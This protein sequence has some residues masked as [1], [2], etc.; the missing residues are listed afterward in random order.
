MAPA[1]YASELVDFSPGESAGFG[2]DSLPD[3]VLGA[4][5]PGHGGAGSLHVLSLGVG[6]SIVLGFG[7][8]TVLD[9][10]GPDLIIFENAFFVGGDPR[11]VFAE[12]AQVAVSTD[13]VHWHPFE[14]EAGDESQGPW[15]GCAGWNPTEDYDVEHMDPLEPERTG[16]DAFDLADLGVKEARYVRITD[17]S[18]AGDAPIA[19]FDLDAV[20]AVHLR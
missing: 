14:C 2:Q 16:G 1:L 13:A 5:H 15:P 7:S 12:L 18:V 20:G 10:P 11:T 9:G 3:I 19:G 17:M 8:Q 4:P 6:G